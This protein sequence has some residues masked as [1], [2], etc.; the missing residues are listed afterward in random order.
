MGVGPYDIEA[1]V[2]VWYCEIVKSGMGQ[3]EGREIICMR[4]L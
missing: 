4:Y 3:C 1:R 2:D